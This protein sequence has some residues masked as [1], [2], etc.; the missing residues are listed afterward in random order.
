MTI[1]LALVALVGQGQTIN[2]R[3]EGN[4]GRPDM[5][6][7]LFVDEMRGTEVDGYISVERIDTLYIVNGKIT[8]VEGT[9]PEPVM[10][11]AYSS[12]NNDLLHI[13][14]ADGTT[15]INGTRGRGVVCQSGN[16]LAEAMDR[17][18]ESWD[19]L[20]QETEQLLSSGRPTDRDALLARMDSFVVNTLMEHP[21]DLIGAACML[22]YCGDICEISPCRGL[23]LMAML[24]S[25]LIAKEPKLLMLMNDLQ[26]RV[27][28]AEGKMFRDFAVEYDG[29]VHRLSDYVGRGQY[30]LVDFWAKWCGPCREEIP[31]VVAAYNKYKGRGLQVVGIACMEP[32]ERSLAFVRGQGIP[33]PQIYNVDRPQMQLYGIDAIPHI[34]LFAPDG[35]ILARGLR[36]DDIGD[37]LEEIFGE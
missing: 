12:H 8:P 27:N 23:E 26:S 14:L 25:S 11:N 3:I 7:T 33:Y 6:D 1:L 28:T 21:D 13:I 16:P 10:A 19:T 34:M 9:L 20:W 37:K 4:I 35:T 2:W 36:G 22:D 29:E 15:R 5:N 32:Q 17:M 30:V 24:D 18:E 31:N